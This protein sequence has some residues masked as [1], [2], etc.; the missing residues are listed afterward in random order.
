MLSISK[1]ISPLQSIFNDAFHKKLISYQSATN[2]IYSP[3][4]ESWGVDY[5]CILVWP[6]KYFE[7]SGHF[8]VLI[9][10][11]REKTMLGKRGAGCPPI[12]FAT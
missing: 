4:P 6:L 1:R 10:C 2:I 8:K 12:T 3:C 7:Q 9:G 11:I 5:G